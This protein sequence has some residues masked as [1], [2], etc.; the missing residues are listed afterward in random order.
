MTRGPE[1]LLVL[2]DG[3]AFHGR[4]FGAAG[5]SFGEVVFNTGMV[6]YQEVLTDPSYAGQVVVMTAP[7]Q[8]NYGTNDE[9]AESSDVQV[10]GFVVR[11]ASRRASSWRARRTLHE[12]LGAAG[13]V[14]IEDV[15]TRRLTLRIR[16]AGAMRCGVSTTDLDP[17]SLTDRVREQSGM[18]GADLAK[19]V[20]APRPYEARELV[21][22]AKAHEG[23]THAV[24]ALD[25]GMKRNILRLLAAEGIEASVFPAQTPPEEIAAGGFE[26]LFL[27]N[28]PG[29]PGAT[30]Y[31]IATTRALLGTVPVFGICLG[32]QLLGHA[33][34]GSTYKMKF[35]HRGVNQ[36]VKD[37]RSGR[38]EITSHNH[39]FAVDAR[40][41][42][43]GLD[44][45]EAAAAG[46]P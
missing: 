11:E 26:G 1:A 44:P 6:G 22:P 16:E 40:S 30:R 4:G 7:Q 9:D 19:N 41:W 28:G 36:P 8:G 25:L 32:H 34:G 29:D 46:E 35:G 24:A 12:E 33:L 15:D 43:D 27:S 31:G 38:V 17:G 42:D 14:G 20:S 5:E 13:V 18:E 45:A 3:T 37:L 23:R 39:G 10:A 21:G 2:E